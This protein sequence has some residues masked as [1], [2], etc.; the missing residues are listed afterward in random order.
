[1]VEMAPGYGD[2]TQKCAFKTCRV[3]LWTCTWLLFTVAWCSQ[4]MHNGMFYLQDAFIIKNMLPLIV[5]N[6]TVTDR[7]MV[8]L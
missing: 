5:R 8:V 3:A 7:H 1:M 4:V 6:V 2:V